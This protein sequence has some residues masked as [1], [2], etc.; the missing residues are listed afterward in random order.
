MSIDQ[1]T[2]TYCADI[3]YPK[4]CLSLS[5]EEYLLTMQKQLGFIKSIKQ[6]AT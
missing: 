5:I 6:L 3:Y 1:N 2:K 4:L